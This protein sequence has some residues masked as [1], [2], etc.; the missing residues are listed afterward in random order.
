MTLILKANLESYTPEVVE[1]NFVQQGIILGINFN[2][3]DYKISSPI[4][5]KPG[6]MA[7]IGMKAQLD[8]HTAPKYQIF[9]PTCTEEINLKILKG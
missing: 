3:Y 5:L 8:L 7:S 4:I 2:P 1:S 9:S 6:T